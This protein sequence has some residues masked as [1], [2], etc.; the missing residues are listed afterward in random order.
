MHRRQIV[1]TLLTLTLCIFTAWGLSG[2]V[3]SG[4]RS[5]TLVMTSD[6]FNM[7][8]GEY[9]ALPA[10]KD[11]TP[12]SIAVLPFTGNATQWK[13]TPESYSPTELVRRGMYNHISSLPF[14][15]LELLNTDRLLANAGLDAESASALLAT[16]PKKLRSILG[17]DAVI[18]GQ[19]T[20]FDRVYMGIFSQVAVGC[21]TQL[22][23]LQSGKL[24]WQAK[25][26]SREFGGGVSITP[27]GLALS[28][29]SSVWNIREEQLD[30]KTDDLFREIVSTL[31]AS[32]PE[33]LQHRIPAAP[34]LDFFA[35][36]SPGEA[37]RTGDE[38]RFK[39]VGDPDCEAYVDLA[40]YKTA[41]QLFPQPDELRSAAY[42][43]ALAAMRTRMETAG[44]PLTPEQEKEAL[45]ILQTRE[46]YEGV[47]TVGPGD[48]EKGILPRGYIINASGGIASAFSGNHPISIDAKPP[49]AP[50]AL[51]TEALDNAASLEWKPSP[52]PDVQRYDVFMAK[53][54]A[55]K[56]TKVLTSGDLTATVHDLVN[57]IPVRFYVIAVDKAGNESAPSKT[58]RIIPVPDKMLA[59]ADMAEQQLGG[60]VRHAYRL[61]ADRS[62]YTVQ[63][64]LTIVQGGSLY[65]EPGVTLLFESSTG[66]LLDGGMLYALGTAAQRISFRPVSKD[67]PSGA[68]SGVT[69]RNNSTLQ[70]RYSDLDRATVAITAYNSNPQ[71]SNV[72]I[73][74]SSQSG[75]YIKRGSNPTFTCG[76][77]NSCAGMG[78]IVTEGIGSTLTIR[79]TVLEGNTPFDMQ[80][81]SPITQDLSGNFWPKPPKIL[82]EIITAPELPSAP[83]CP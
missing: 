32:L 34:H 82:G 19:V 49:M 69:I 24:L 30:R 17:V 3:A 72:T 26:I 5:G 61:T 65:L 51:R 83:V 20:A 27:V 73:S 70:M 7:F 67:A 36:T 71:F 79:D 13:T 58:Q 52:S 41:I 57:F 25:H 60:I 56:F 1:T 68:W 64:P 54:D 35:L 37:F 31:E 63:S 50:L 43:Q 21:A 4:K 33:S 44:T 12:R 18:S 15:D 78:A 62:P 74:D 11:H 28:A 48:V 66:I 40:D 59:N 10:L 81:F 23:D 9:E 53:G 39:L 75:L 47:I 8:N 46:V 14:T 22:T 55:I 16:N 42:T 6:A 76:R 80:N 77:I 29:I 45:A 38:L 2:C